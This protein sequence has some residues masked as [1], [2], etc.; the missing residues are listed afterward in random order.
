MQEL[1]TRLETAS[2]VVED[3]VE[4]HGIIGHGYDV[5]F[6]HLRPFL[7]RQSIWGRV[8]YQTRSW[9]GWYLWRN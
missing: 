4:V 3:L 7:E 5:K 6:R 9:I 8:I 1:I 2:E